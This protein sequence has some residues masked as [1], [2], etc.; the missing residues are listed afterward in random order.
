[1]KGEIDCAFDDTANGSD[2]ER[3]ASRIKAD[4]DHLGEALY[5]IG[6]TLNDAK[7][8]LKH[9]TFLKFLCDERVDYGFRAA[10]ILME[11]ARAE[12]GR[13][14]AALGIAKAMQMLR[15]SPEQRDDLV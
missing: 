1:M 4:K 15:L 8:K 7:S 14:L 10:Q 9:G 13:A 3:L 11:I 2:Y 12:D 5:D 6:L